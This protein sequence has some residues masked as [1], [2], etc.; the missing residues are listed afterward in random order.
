MI[1]PIGKLCINIAIACC[2]LNNFYR[3]FRE[4]EYIVAEIEDAEEIWSCL[5][6][7]FIGC[8]KGIGNQLVKLIF[9]KHHLVVWFIYTEHKVVPRFY[10]SVTP[11]HIIMIFLIFA[12]DEHMSVAV[13][14]H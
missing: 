1:S 13:A 6:A 9:L 7:Q 5:R 8:T 3:F 14:E 4:F 10:G 2:L 12:E 11:H